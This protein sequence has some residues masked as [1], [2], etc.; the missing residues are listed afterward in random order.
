MALLTI[1]LTP[2]RLPVP[3]GRVRNPR[4]F[5]A[6]APARCGQPA[7]ST[8]G[9]AAAAPWLLI[10]PDLHILRAHILPRRHR[11]HL[12]FLGLE[13][14]TEGTWPNAHCGNCRGNAVQPYGLGPRMS[15]MQYCFL[16]AARRSLGSHN[17]DLLTNR[18]PMGVSCASARETRESSEIRQVVKPTGKRLRAGHQ[19]GSSGS[20]PLF[21]TLI[22]PPRVIPN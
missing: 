11:Q 16:A 3:P 18:C 7:G 14:Q 6:S 10:L 17:G 9:P 1:C 19:L 4:R 2:C 15:V 12:G 21:R 5:T 13:G 8:S 20:T 22:T